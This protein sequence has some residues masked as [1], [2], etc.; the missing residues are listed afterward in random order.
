ME[1]CAI[2]HKKKKQE[3][4][5]VTFC[6]FEGV[7]HHA[8]IQRVVTANETVHKARL[9]QTL[10]MIKLSSSTMTPT[11]I[12]FDLIQTNCSVNMLRAATMSLYSLKKNCHCLSEG[13]GAC[14]LPSG[15]TYIHAA[16]RKSI[17]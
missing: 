9:L 12:H 15:C 17:A 13:C 10:S 6:Y 1:S 7:D 5:S 14:G 4:S 8:S 3:L 11:E 2:F 16:D